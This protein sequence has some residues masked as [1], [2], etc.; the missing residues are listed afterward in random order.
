[1]PRRAFH[2]SANTVRFHIAFRIIAEDAPIFIHA[3]N[4][5]FGTADAFHAVV[6]KSRF[7][8]FFDANTR[9]IFL[10]RFVADAQPV[11]RDAAFARTDFAH[12]F[13]RAFITMLYHIGT[14]D[15]LIARHV[16][17]RLT[18][19][20]FTSAVGLLDIAPETFLA[21]PAIGA[22]N[23]APFAEAFFA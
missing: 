16:F 23:A 20:F 13:I 8:R 19:H 9:F 3:I 6:V 15:A 7:T 17:V 12:R 1:M 18:D 22:A 14:F 2:F 5:S 21:L 11:L 10:P 4:T